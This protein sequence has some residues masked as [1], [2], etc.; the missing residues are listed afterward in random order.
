[1]KKLYTAKWDL[2]ETWALEKIAKNVKRW[3]TIT[4]NNHM[5]GN[6]NT[7]SCMSFYRFRLENIKSCVPWYY[8]PRPDHPGRTDGPRPPGPPGTDGQT[9]TNLWKNSFWIFFTI[10]YFL[11]C[12]AMFFYAFLCFSAAF[13]DFPYGTKG[14]VLPFPFWPI[15]PSHRCRRSQVPRPPPHGM[16]SRIAAGAAAGCSR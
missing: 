15:F 6:H 14:Y 9:K 8:G 13:C 7:C 11:L 12:F 10:F 16:V 4:K 5:Q 2:E 3:Q 1:M